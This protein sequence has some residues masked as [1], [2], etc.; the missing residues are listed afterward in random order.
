MNSVSAAGRGSR[1]LKSEVYL[2]KE[3][4]RVAPTHPQ[5]GKA[6]EEKKRGKQL[7]FH[8]CLGIGFL[9]IKKAERQGT[10]SI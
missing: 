10:H 9:S 5:M 6:K 4:K 2:Q 3:A 1:D 8:V 7:P